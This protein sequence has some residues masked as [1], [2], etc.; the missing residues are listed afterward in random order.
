MRALVQLSPRL[1][2]RRYLPRRWHLEC[3]MLL[4]SGLPLPLTPRRGLLLF[5]FLCI[6]CGYV[7]DRDLKYIYNVLCWYRV[8]FGMRKLKIEE[9]EYTLDTS[10]HILKHIRKH[11]HC[12]DY[13]EIARVLPHRI[14]IISGVCDWFEWCTWIM[15]SRQHS[16]NSPPSLMFLAKQP[17][18]LFW[19][20][21][22]WEIRNSKYG[23]V[24]W[25]VD[26]QLRNWRSSFSISQLLPGR[27]SWRNVLGGNF[28]E[29]YNSLC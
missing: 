9:N 18:K 26:P 23:S 10:L 13:F 22:H 21:K 7:I 12:R 27:S 6:C 24:H 25:E 4:K 15:K 19:F 11:H 5:F 1:N 14:L 17:A 28:A 29:I 3:H 8:D 2:H 16:S 20:A